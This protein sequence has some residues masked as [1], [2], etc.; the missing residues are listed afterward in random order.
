MRSTF[1][2]TVPQALYDAVSDACG[3]PFADSYLYGAEL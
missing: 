3:Q 1:L 2:L